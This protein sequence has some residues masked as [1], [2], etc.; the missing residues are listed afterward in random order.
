MQKGTSP[1]RACSEELERL[2]FVSGN[3]ST[4]LGGRDVMGFLDSGR[5]RPPQAQRII[6]F[7]CFAPEQLSKLK[8]GVFSFGQVPS[9]IEVRAGLVEGV[10]LPN[11]D[12]RQASM[13]ALC[14]HTLA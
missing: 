11:S 3:S 7:G 10:L 1:A 4:V 2:L 13:R 5:E 12:I 14:Q 8:H 6:A 9:P